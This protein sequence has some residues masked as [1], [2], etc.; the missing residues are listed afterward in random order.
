MDS[1]PSS[2]PF[3]RQ[4]AQK[5]ATCGGPCSV[6]GGIRPPTRKN[7]DAN[8]AGTIISGYAPCHRILQRTGSLLC[9]PIHEKHSSND[10]GLLSRLLDGWPRNPARAGQP[11]LD[12]F[13]RRDKGNP[14]GGS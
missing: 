8:F 5:L 1:Q 14:R 10:L 9:N 6:G 2:K 4:T 12:Q 3:W 7:R 13:A 11:E